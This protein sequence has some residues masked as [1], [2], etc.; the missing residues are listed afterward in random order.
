M[1][2]LTYIS[3]LKA[4]E[5]VHS[6]TVH[7]HQISLLMIIHADFII[8]H[9]NSHH[10]LKGADLVVTIFSAHKTTEM[11]EAQKGGVADRM[12]DSARLAETPPIGS[13]ISLPPL[14]KMTGT[15]Q[16]Y[17]HDPHSLTA[18]FSIAYLLSFRR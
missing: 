9:R 15:S 4:V 12:I 14:A 5:F 16:V 13:L 7:V 18:F 2:Q 11:I 17:Q 1:Q 10:P 3:P 8:T 6:I